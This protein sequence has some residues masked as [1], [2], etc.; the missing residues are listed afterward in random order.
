MQE[1]QSEVRTQPHT[2]ASGLSRR[3]PSCPSDVGPG[4]CCSFLY[5]VF[6]L[7]WAWVSRNQT[8]FLQNVFLQ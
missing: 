3:T 7:H 2:P 5:L 8:R 4:L 6:Q 1:V